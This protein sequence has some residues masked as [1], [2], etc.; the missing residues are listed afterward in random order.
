MLRGRQPS[1]LADL[2]TVRTQR[3]V[4]TARGATVAEIVEDDVRVLRSNQLVKRFR[5]LEVELRAAASDA[6]LPRLEKQLRKRGAGKV[7]PVTKA[8]IALDGGPLE[9]ALPATHLHDNVTIFELVRATL[10]ASVDR[11]VRVDPT[12]RAS[13]NADAVHDAR[14]SVRK[15]RSHLRTF[16]PVTD[17]AWAGDLSERLRWLGDVLGAARDA[18]VLVAGLTEHIERLPSPDRRQAEQALGLFRAPRDSAYYELGRV[19]R[20]PA[21]AEV[22]ETT[23]AAACAPMVHLPQRSAASVM[24]Q[25]MQRVWRKLRKRVRRAGLQPT[26]RDLHRIRIHAKHLRY[27]AEALMPI[28]GNA[29]RR[30]ARRAEDLQA[31]LGKQHDAVAADIALHAHVH[32]GAHAFI[33]GEF[34]AIRRADSERYRER[35]PR[36]W[37]RLARR[38]RRRFWV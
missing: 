15:L 35:F 36:C 29:A 38:K 1:P 13:P 31:L 26:D 23:I 19:L 11:L 10:A 9:P 22:L 30:F 16:A 28:A 18:D 4:R 6:V 32:D 27:A 20:D 12:L 17:R 21:Y 34:A 7:N 37:Q 5:Q 8:A 3:D 33:G 14:V 24:P 2:R 25:L